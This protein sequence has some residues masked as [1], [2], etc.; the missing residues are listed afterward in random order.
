MNTKNKYSLALYLCASAF[1]AQAWGGEPSVQIKVDLSPAGSFMAKT[2]KVKGVAQIKGNQVSASNVVVEAG[3][4]D[5]GI[6]LRNKHMRE[7]YLEAQ[8]Y[9]EAELISATGVNG[10]GKGQ[11]KVH[12]VVHDITG[13]YKMLPGNMAEARFKTKASDYNIAEAQYMGVGAEDE[14]EVIVTLPVVRATK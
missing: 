7:K 3:S 8:K 1:S 12:G 6:S 5:T 13:T 2:N 11:L 10:V 4:F 9:P 14:V